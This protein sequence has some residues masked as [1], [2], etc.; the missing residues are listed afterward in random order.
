MVPSYYLVQNVDAVFPYRFVSADRKMKDTPKVLVNSLVGHEDLIELGTVVRVKEYFKS[1][2]DRKSVVRGVLCWFP[3]NQYG[4][5]LSNQPP[6]FL[7]KV[8]QPNRKQEAGLQRMKE[9]RSRSHNI[10]DV[11]TDEP[12]LLPCS[13]MNVKRKVCDLKIA[14]RGRTQYDKGE[15]RDQDHRE[16][17]RKWQEI[18]F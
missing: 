6:V 8:P 15:R 7:C 9:L 5:Q 13:F 1:R 12:N 2:H 14:K 17:K 4:E 10:K 3:C 11:L 16:R 18:S